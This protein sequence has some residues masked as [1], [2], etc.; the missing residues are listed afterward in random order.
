MTAKRR[1]HPA[2]V[3]TWLTPEVKAWLRENLH[4]GSLADSARE[5]HRLFGFRV[6]VGQLNSANANHKFGRANRNVPRAYSA[7]ELAWLAKN[8]PRA[9][10]AD[11]RRGFRSRFGRTIS[12]SALDNLANKYDWQGAPNTG[13]FEK[14]H[15]PANK[16]RK[17]YAA[18]GSE[19]GWFRPGAVPANVRPLWSERWTHIGEG[20]RKTPALEIKVP[21]PAPWESHRR[22]GMN[23]ETHW[24]RKAV[25]V[26]TQANGPVPP[27]HV[28]LQVDGDP[29]N[30]DPSNLECV[31]RAV[32]A[33]LNRHSSP[34]Y[35]GPEVNPARV[36]LA[37]LKVAV[38]ERS[39]T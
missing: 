31:P 15:V 38:T 24:V 22:R 26:W 30:C 3:R 21:G 33:A 27:G 8:V 4:K 29:A 36:R 6:T 10:R 17:G 1:K 11:I 7:E 20:D 18:P 34:V 16:G 5:I 19:K 28:V 12:V 23:R 39:R 25:W 13:R 2:I 37:Q 32:M 14:G 9:P 35:A